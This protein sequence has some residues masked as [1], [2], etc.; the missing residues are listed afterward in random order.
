[1]ESRLIKDMLAQAKQEIEMCE[2]ALSVNETLRL[3]YHVE[4]ALKQVKEIDIAV[5]SMGR[6]SGVPYALSQEDWK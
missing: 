4:R 2:F 1:M 6:V 5:F 3:A